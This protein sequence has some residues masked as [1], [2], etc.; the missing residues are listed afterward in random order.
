MERTA[1]VGRGAGEGTIAELVDDRAR[2]KE[3]AAQTQAGRARFAHTA[4]GRP[5]RVDASSSAAAVEGAGCFKLPLLRGNTHPPT[6]T[7]GPSTPGAPAPP[8]GVSP[9]GRI[10]LVWPRRPAHSLQQAS[11]RPQRGGRALKLNTTSPMLFRGGAATATTSKNTGSLQR[12]P[13]ATW[14]R[15]CLPSAQR[16]DR[17]T[18]RPD[19]PDGSGRSDGR[20]CPFGGQSSRDGAIMD[21][22]AGAGRWPLCLC[23]SAVAR[24]WRRL[25]ASPDAPVLAAAHTATHALWPAVAP[26]L[27][28]G[29]QRC[30][31]NVQRR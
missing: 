5:D 6:A 23:K 27:V 10:A 1:S 29:Q 7:K 28:T 15:Y 20:A 31:R 9:T 24:Y 16:T 13:C 2:D 17:Q 3:P 30:E 12:R 14:P 18:D 19:R 22:G 4:G 11:G 21:T 25:H 26:P 8:P